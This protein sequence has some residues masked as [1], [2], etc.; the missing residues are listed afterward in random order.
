MC[1]D[2]L[3]LGY[4]AQVLD[5]NKFDL[6]HIDIMDLNFVPNIALSFNTVK[7]LDKFTIPKDVHLMVK[8]VPLALKN[9]TVKAEDFISFHVETS[10]SI[11]N[12]INLIR[13]L[14]ARPGLVINP[15]T[16]IEKIRPYLTSIDIIHIMTANPGLSGQSFIP[17]SL[18]KAKQL[19]SIIL[20]QNKKILL[21]ADGGIGFEQIEKLIPC[22]VDIFVL[23]TTCLFNNNF[24]EQIK[25][26]LVFKKNIYT[27]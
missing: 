21:G 1:A 23:G 20:N 7:A 19:R 25:K 16:S 22:G 13:K 4:Q 27:I 6:F 3:R 11:E 18:D 24:E 5:K 14:G 9:I 17:H 12:N 15:K 26:L 2:P 10:T 8:D